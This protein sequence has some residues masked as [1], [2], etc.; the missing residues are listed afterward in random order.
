[1]HNKKRHLKPELFILLKKIH[2]LFD[3][4]RANALTAQDYGFQTQNY[5]NSKVKKKA[6]KSGLNPLRR[7]I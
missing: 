5:K 1:M 4:F 2:T 6:K 3:R 7:Q